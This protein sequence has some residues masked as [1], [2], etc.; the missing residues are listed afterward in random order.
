MTKILI[1]EDEAQT[2]D[3]F[4]KCLT[5]EGFFAIAAENGA[6]GIQLAQTH[7]PD[8][9]VCDIM[10]PDLDGYQVLAAIRQ[11]PA[12]MATPLIFLTAKVTMLDL[13]CGMDVGADDYLTKPCTVE[14]FLVAITTRLER[15]AAL[16]RC[17]SAGVE[18]PA[19]PMVE[20]PK[21]LAPDRSVFPHSP[22]LVPTFQFIEAN[23]AQPI[24]LREVADAVGYS[25][26]YLTT[27][28]QTLTGYSIKQWITERR[29]VQARKLLQTTDQPVRQIADAVGYSD[30]GYFT[31]QF[32]QLHGAPPQH[33]RTSTRLRSA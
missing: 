1:I 20:A 12:I 26:A 4:V 17:F 15:Q 7:C 21:S 31:R 18:V 33:W 23:Y 30:V 10:M 27:L 25:P 28:A 24:G 14:Q 8:L 19:L 32:R 5:L 16:K 3:I 13:R 2:R 29:M 11:H 6:I 22:K 9:I